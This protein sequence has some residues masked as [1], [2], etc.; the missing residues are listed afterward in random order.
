[1]T[2]KIS[3]LNRFFSFRNVNQSR[4][5]SGISLDISISETDRNH[6]QQSI[7]STGVTAVGNAIRTISHLICRPPPYQYSHQ[8]AR[9]VNSCD[10]LSPPITPISAATIISLDGPVESPM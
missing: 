2:S 8:N 7:A 1:M 9:N 5:R 10:S 6:D 3:F 4:G